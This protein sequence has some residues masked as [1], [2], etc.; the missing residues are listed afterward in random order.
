MAH[1]LVDAQAFTLAQTVRNMAN[2]PTSQPNWPETYLQQIGRLYLIIQGF[3]NFDQLPPIPQNAALAQ[4][5]NQIAQQDDLTAL[6][7]IAGTVALHQQTGWQPGQIIPPDPIPQQPE[8]PICSLNIGRGLELLLGGPHAA[9]QPE[10]L[11]ALAQTNHRLP[12]F[13]LPNLLEK[14]AKLTKLRPY[15]P[16]LPH[17]QIATNHAPS[18]PLKK[19]ALA[20]QCGLFTSHF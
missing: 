20:P 19:S 4:L 13:L 6:L 3:G 9:L 5:L 10:I 1:R 7:A 14:G 16:K 12:D 18:L 8:Q 15:T 17:A 2:V 11:A